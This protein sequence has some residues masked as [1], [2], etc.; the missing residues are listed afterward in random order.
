MSKTAPNGRENLL[1]G[2]LSPGI[3]VKGKKSE[4]RLRGGNLI[5][6]GTPSSGRSLGH[7]QETHQ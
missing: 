7:S 1:V 3:C 2:P 5:N 6:W 4:A